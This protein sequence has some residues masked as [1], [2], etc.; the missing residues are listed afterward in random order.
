MFAQV[1]K[2]SRLQRSSFISVVSN[3]CD[4]IILLCAIRPEAECPSSLPF[5]ESGWGLVVGKKGT[6]NETC[7]LKVF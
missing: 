6:K 1:S 5:N 7:L 4:F 3:P 2:G